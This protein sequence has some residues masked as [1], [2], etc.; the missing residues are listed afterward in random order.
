MN[1]FFKLFP[2]SD[3][4]SPFPL[5]HLCPSSQ[6]MTWIIAVAS[7]LLSLPWTLPAGYSLHSSWRILWATGVKSYQFLPTTLE[8]CPFHSES[9]PR[10]L[11]WPTWPYGSA[12]LPLR[13]PLLLLLPLL[14]FQPLWPPC[15]SSKCLPTSG[16]LHLLF[17]LLETPMH[18][19]PGIHVAPSLASFRF[20]L[21]WHLPREALLTTPPKISAPFTLYPSSC[22]V[23]LHSLSPPDVGCIYLLSSSTGQ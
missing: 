4:F 5:Y 12:L 13:A 22:L 10:S 18:I 3:H 20:L 7:S 23:F 19:P 21:D 6:Q 1:M 14:L 15:Y 8:W 2:K 16:P 17:F 9:E 11:Q